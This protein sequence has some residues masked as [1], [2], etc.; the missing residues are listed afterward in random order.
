MECNVTGTVDTSAY[1]AHRPASPPLRVLRS[2]R[3][4]ALDARDTVLGRHDPL[5]PPR[6]LVLVG[7]SQDEF[8][9]IG[10][11]WVETFAS[12]C[13]LGRFDRVL[14]I[15]CGIG[16]VAAGL[17]RYLDEL[18]SYEGMD[19]VPAGIEWCRRSITPRYPNFRFQLSDV[20]NAEYNPTGRVHASQYRFPWRDGE[21]DFVF[22]TSAFTHMLPR[23]V[24]NYLGEIA[25]VMRPGARCVITYFLLNDA[26][27]AQLARGEVQPG[28][29]FRHEM[30]GCLAVHR[31]NPAIAVA[32]PEPVV[33]ELYERHRLRILKTHYG[34]W[35]GTP[36]ARHIQDYVVAEKRPGADAGLGAA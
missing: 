34:A 16:R 29:E 17:A 33:H 20:H 24:E 22:L 18:G 32:Y 2:L 19:V 4:R 27:R 35:C 10:Q 12:Q 6:R 30:D 11:Q 21:F 25:R 9:A 15:G 26:S 7:S 13:G 5:V 14:D 3:D 36:G 23:D 8:R 28:R 31:D 1:P